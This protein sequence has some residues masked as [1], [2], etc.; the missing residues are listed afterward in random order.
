[1][2][3]SYAGGRESDPATQSQLE[4][5]SIRVADRISRTDFQVQRLKLPKMAPT[6]NF[7]FFGP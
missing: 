4:L 7:S 6:I 3:M 2:V 5:K 1:M